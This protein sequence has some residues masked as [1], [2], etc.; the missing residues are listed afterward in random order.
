ME[1]YQGNKI[2]KGICPICDSFLSII[3]EEAYAQCCI[4]R[5]SFVYYPESDAW[6]VNTLRTRMKEPE[7]PPA[8]PSKKVGKVMVEIETDVDPFLTQ[9]RVI[10]CELFS[11]THN[12]GEGHCNLKKIRINAAG[13]C[14]NRDY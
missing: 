12:D 9:T 4:C 3:K 6:K 13:N 5:H 2:D 11:C 7:I 1:W 14:D 8:S 10:E